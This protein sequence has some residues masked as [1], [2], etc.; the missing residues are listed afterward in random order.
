MTRCQSG[1]TPSGRGILIL[2]KFGRHITFIM[3]LCHTKFQIAISNS[4]EM[5]RF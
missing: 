2:I 4:V 5:A 3:K 1:Q